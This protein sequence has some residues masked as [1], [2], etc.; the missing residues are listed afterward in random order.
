M[1]PLGQ[2]IDTELK[3]DA[4]R[5]YHERP[6]GS[7]QF[8]YVVYTFPNS[9]DDEI[10]E[11]FILEVNIW[12]NSKNTLALE[13]LATDISKRLNRVKHV[14]GTIA[15]HIYK[16]NQLSVPDPDTAIRRRQVRFE[17]RTYTIKE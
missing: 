16:V 12:G 7:P 13:Q 9:I 14:Y 5:V 11:D 4:A 8:P 2:F 15:T 1:I 17:C 10:R 6:E 3:K